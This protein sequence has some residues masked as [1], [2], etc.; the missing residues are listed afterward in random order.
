MNENINKSITGC[1]AKK[2]EKCIPAEI[3]GC[4][5]SATSTLPVEIAGC[6]KIPEGS[7]LANMVT[8]DAKMV[9]NDAK[10]VANVAKMVINEAKR[11]TKLAFNLV[12]KNDVNLALP[13]RFLQVLIE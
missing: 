6:A 13:P 4:A 11:V 1:T 12:V 3:V 2:S 8:N 9:T 5:N 7:E 10:M